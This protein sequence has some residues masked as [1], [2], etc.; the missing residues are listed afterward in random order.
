MSEVGLQNVTVRYAHVTALERVTLMIPQGEFLALLG[1]SGCGK[2]TTIKLIAGFIAPEEGDVTIGQEKVNHLPPHKRKVGMV[3]QNYA[4]FP[5][6][7]VAG[8]IAFGLRMKK[9]GRAEIQRKV[10]EVLKVLHL[11]GFEDRY[12]HQL[13]GGQQ[14]R[15]ALA[16]ALVVNPSV[17]LLD[18]PLGA[19]DKKLREEMQIE[20]R[21]LQKRFGI[22]TVFVTHDQEEALTMADRIAIMNKGRIEQVGAPM[23]I[24]EYPVNR[25]V[26]DFIGISNILTLRVETVEERQIRCRFADGQPL[27]VATGEGR[28]CGE[29]LEVAIRPEKIRL[30]W[31]RPKTEENLLPGTVE[32][33]I[34]RGALTLV[35]VKVAEET[36]LIVQLQNVVDSKGVEAGEK[37]YVTWPVNACQVLSG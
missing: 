36:T 27:V 13:S 23:E 37:V 25:F 9:E 32:R 20:L 10:T 30:A 2:T 8:N 28:A 34:Y 3:F 16:R 14:Q 33:K 31:E 29:R 18:E 19:L 22:T 1:P 24:Y 7:T 35:Y 12:T 6:K 5:H 11:E 17:L 26:S 21:G 15:V 4:L